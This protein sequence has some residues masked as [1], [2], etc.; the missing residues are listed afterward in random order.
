L[1]ATLTGEAKVT[2]V[3]APTGETVELVPPADAVSDASMAGSLI[4]TVTAPICC[5]ALVVFV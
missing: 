5:V 4:V 3:V 1:P 2:L